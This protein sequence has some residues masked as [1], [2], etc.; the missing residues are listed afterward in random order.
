MA[1]ASTPFPFRFEKAQLP[2][3]VTSTWKAVPA[4]K[5]I[6]T[7]TEAELDQAW[8]VGAQGMTAI[9]THG[10][11]TNGGRDSIQDTHHIMDM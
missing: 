2:Y 4:V 6:A 3:A 5:G 8:G 7:L 9:T 1:S 11:V 10:A